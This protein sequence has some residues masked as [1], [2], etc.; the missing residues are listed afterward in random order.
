MILCN[1]DFDEKK[2]TFLFFSL[3]RQVI[4]IQPEKN[5]N[6][7]NVFINESGEGERTGALTE[8]FRRLL[9]I[10]VFKVKKYGS[11]L[12]NDYITVSEVISH[13]YMFLH[14]G[15]SLWLKDVEY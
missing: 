4:I 2:K 3:K 5:I 8:A 10:G 14:E 13:H 12:L 6:G 11:L 9:T 7:L 15:E 1:L